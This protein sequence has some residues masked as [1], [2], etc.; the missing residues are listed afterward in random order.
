MEFTK[1]DIHMHTTIS[2]G[3]NTPAEILQRVK[4]KGIE[5]FSITD[6]DAILGGIEMPEM[7]EKG[8]PAFV[9]GCEFSCKDE[10]GK[11]HI[12]GYG[13]DPDVPGVA[14]VVEKGHELRMKKTMGRLQF[15]EEEF[16]IVFP[17]EELDKLLAMPNPGKPHIGNLMA[18]LGYAKDRNEAITEF[19]DKRKYQ[20]EYVRPEF[21][22]EGILKSG[23]IPVLAHPSYG[24]GNDLI[25]GED[26]E[27]RVKRLM[28]FGLAGL[29]AY[30][31]GFN[32]K[33]QNQNL[34]LAEK[35]D[36]YVT[37]GS[38]Y[39]GENKLVVLG[40]TNLEDAHDGPAGMERFLEDVTIIRP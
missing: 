40:D 36:L 12:L 29:E 28:E 34:A 22:I 38:D 27:E 24:N 1:I 20:S 23:G 11:Y 17:Q 39:H 37:A 31:S 18:K 25:M 16:G 33:L 15:L 13:Y 4:D 26:L 6:H 32:E 2:D 30:Y 7:L 3:T 35:Y 8:D 9:R 14:E 21:A 10:L 19:I 5:L